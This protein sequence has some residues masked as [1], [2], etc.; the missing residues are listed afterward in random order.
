M[1]ATI[2]K[3]DAARR[4]A[5]AIASDITLYNEAKID[6]AIRED[7]LFEALEGEIQEGR[8]L[9]QQR[10]V[11]ELHKL[12]HYDRALVDVLLR[13]KGHINSKIW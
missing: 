5:R 12:N 3:P 9:F 8:E 4:L 13:S 1:P 10:V 2:D 11:P 7:N 6:Q